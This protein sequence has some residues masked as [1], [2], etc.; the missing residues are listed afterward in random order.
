MKYTFLLAAAV[1]VATPTWAEDG[2]KDQT[3]PQV[4]VSDT[5]FL[6]EAWR[7]EQTEMRMA[8]LALTQAGSSSVKQLGDQLLAAHSRITEDLKALAKQKA[9]NIWGDPDNIRIAELR[10]LSGDAFDREYLAQTVTRHERAIADFE[11]VVKTSSDPELKAF[12]AKSLGV[13]KGH[14]AMIKGLRT[15]DA[16]APSKAST[17]Q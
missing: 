9:V 17:Q 7:R 12:A 1:L 15:P 3:R 6:T 10:Q 8:E 11:N 14:L 2:L 5:S 13:M 16:V 4:A